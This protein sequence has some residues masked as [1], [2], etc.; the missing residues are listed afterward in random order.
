MGISSILKTGAKAFKFIFTDGATVVHDASRAAFKAS[1]GQSIFTRFTTSTG[2]AKKAFSD[3][4][5][6]MPIKSR[7]Y[8]AIKKAWTDGISSAGQNLSLGGKIKAGFKGLFLGKHGVKGLW[9]SGVLT[10][11]KSV[12]A[13]GGKVGSL[14]KLWGGLKGVCKP[15]TKMPMLGTIITCLF[16]VPDIVDSFKQ[17][18]E[19]GWKQVGRSAT[20][21]SCALLGSFAA[22]FIPVPGMSIVGFIAGEW[23]GGLLADGIF[24]KKPEVETENE[25]AENESVDANTAEETSSSKPEVST[26]TDSTPSTQN[27]SED[28]TVQTP[29]QTV[30]IPNSPINDSVSGIGS[31]NPFGGGLAMNPSVGFG[32]GFSQPFGPGIGMTNPFGTGF[33]MNLNPSIGFGSGLANPFGI[34]FGGYQNPYI[35]SINPFLQPGENIFQ[36]YP[37][38]YQFQ[39]IG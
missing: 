31:G 32:A 16:E 13:K 18:P 24:G 19:E 33:G 7:T 4:I 34:G 20:K 10:Q 5:K 17:N 14:T 11:A 1:K 29:D 23:L 21:V 12:L 8:S 36:K 35:S 26:V 22:S 2:A 3:G 38:G 9:K 30:T 28:S 27:A 39:Y 15:L 6:N 25:Q 37:M